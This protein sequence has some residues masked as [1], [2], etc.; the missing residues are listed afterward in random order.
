MDNFADK[1][2][3]FESKI[4]IIDVDG[5]EISYHHLVALAEQFASRLNKDG[6]QLL[7][8]AADN[9]LEAIVAYI[10]ALR[11]RIPVVLAPHDKPDT[12]ENIERI[13]QPS[14]IYKHQNNKYELSHHPEKTHGQIDYPPELAVLLSTSGT[15]GSA[16]LVKLSSDNINANAN[17]I[18]QY[19]EID[20]TERAIISL[21]MYYSYGLSVINSHLA[22]G[23]SIVLTQESVIEDKFWNTFNQYKCTSFAGVPY[24]Y[25]LLNR[26]GFEKRD[27]PTMRYLTQAG[28]RLPVAL[29]EQFASSFKKKNWRFYVMYGQTEATARMSYVPVDK[30]ASCPS[31]IGVAIPGG[32]FELHDESGHLIKEPNVVGELIYRGPNVM[33]GYANSREELF[34]DQHLSELETGD[35]ASRDVQGLYYISGRK[36]RF[37]KL[38]GNRI[39]LDDLETS[40]RSNGWV[41]ICGG[42]DNHLI[43]LTLEK[44]KKEAIETLL[45]SKF[46][47][48]S[49]YASVLEVGGF[50]LLPSGKIDYQALAKLSEAKFKEITEQS[51]VSESDI[52]ADQISVINAFAK[53]FPDKI[54]DQES[55]FN[56]LG[57]DSLNYVQMMMLLEKAIGN[58]PSH[59]QTMSVSQLQQLVSTKKTGQFQPIE[60]SVL[61]RAVAICEVVLNHSGVI[62][63]RMADGGA[64]IFFLLAGYSFSRFQFGNVLNISVWK[65]LG[66][67]IKHLVVPYLLV[68]STLLVFLYVAGINKSPR[69]DL[70]LLVSNLYRGEPLD[71]AFL[72]FIEVLVQCLVILG[73]IFSVKPVREFAKNH[74]W[75]F[76]L[77]LLLTLS[78]LCLFIESKWNTDY[79]D[80]R[81]P[82]I[83]IVL[84]LIGQSI[85]LS[86]TLMRRVI[87]ISLSM[88]IVAEMFDEHILNMPISVWLLAGSGLLVFMPKINIYSKLK[89]FINNLALAA[90][91]IYLLHMFF[92]ISLDR[93]IKNHFVNALLT[94][95]VCV[96]IAKVHFRFKDKLNPRVLLKI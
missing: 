96:V 42:T 23:A 27:L 13:Y 44:G 86:D 72:W 48:S 94:I 68:C 73:L 32:S 40:F 16:K 39:S 71:T 10:A 34:T 38:F 76:S 3:D 87:T 45:L 83:Y 50:P 6:K 18:I 95:L 31:S 88:V 52:G 56:S 80:N 19:L 90:F 66:N 47:L 57:G 20:E 12:I 61:V 22:A 21:P 82:H 81:V 91:Y 67:S 46:K 7:L 49:H 14:L 51:Q 30:L 85:Y 70:L 5:T 29:V 60:T 74:M 69:Y 62:P 75:L 77:I 92:L 84:F 78:I 41:T 58:V 89:P 33:I 53:T 64:A 54:V 11:C 43:V 1:L 9:S 59:W 37:L 25:E 17:S 63:S 79:L 15:T 24:T 93:I 28:G 36:S 55:T 65:T 35:L 26:T 4:A 8:L 2:D